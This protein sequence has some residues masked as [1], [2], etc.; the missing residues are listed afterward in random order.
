MALEHVLSSV[1]TVKDIHDKIK[2]NEM[3][4]FR[5]FVRRLKLPQSS[6]EQSKEQLVNQLSECLITD[7]GKRR[8]S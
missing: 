4:T 8:A 7:D 3:Q 5:E 1:Y 2:N 6:M